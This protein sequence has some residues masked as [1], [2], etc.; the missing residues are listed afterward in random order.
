MNIRELLKNVKNPLIIGHH[1]ADPDAVC[2]MIAFERLYRMI[3][4]EGTPTLIADDSSRL[5][6]QVLRHFAPDVS[7]PKKSD[8][9]HDFHV[10][11]DTNSRF[12]LGPDLQDTVTDPNK[13]LVIDHH[14]PNPEIESL[15]KHQIVHSDK[16]STCEI[17]VDVYNELEI[18]IDSDT[19]NLLLAGMLF[20]TRR[21]FYADS[22][23][24]KAAIKLIEAGANYEQCVKSLLIRP[25]RSERIARLKAAGRVK[26][27]LVGDWIV[28]ISKINAFEASTCRGLI[29]LGADVAIVG[30][31][32]RKDTVRLSSRSTRP[33]F[34]T[35]G[36]NLGT[37][38]MDPIGEMIDG[39]G[40]GHANAAGANGK[41][42]LDKALTKSLEIIKS[43]IE[44]KTEEGAE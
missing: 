14:E 36:I 44:G 11:I 35:T 41:R 20:D 29:E 30:G 9:T 25:D 19:A 31:N 2:A 1:N 21:F 22:N 16:S 34:E 42:D 37:D 12:Q 24:L 5:S 10:L 38:I 39:E 13:T 23:T 33:F 3:N 32:P 6:N 28:A 7:I 8:K 17:L 27:H 40:G 4:P 26:V 18:E 15:S 43:A